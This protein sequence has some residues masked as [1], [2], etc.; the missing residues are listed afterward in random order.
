MTEFMT[1]H[2]GTFLAE[3][4]IQLWGAEF[5]SPLAHALGVS[6]RTVERWARGTRGT[7][8]VIWPKIIAL[9]AEKEARVQ[10]IRH[11][12]TERCERE[13]YPQRDPVEPKVDP[14]IMEHWHDDPQ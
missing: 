10:A 8:P 14:E 2:P 5:V 11:V 4:A 3:C 13:D 9:L 12:L 7:P 6:K 1:R